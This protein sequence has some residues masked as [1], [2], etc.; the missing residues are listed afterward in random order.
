LFLAVGAFVISWLEVFSLLPATLQKWIEAAEL[1]QKEYALASIIGGALQAFVSALAVMSPAQRNADKYEEMLSLLNK[2]AD[3]ELARVR[4]VVA[5]GS[6][7]AIISVDEFTTRVSRDLAEEARE[8]LLLHQ[9]LSDQTLGRSTG[10]QF[11]PAT[12]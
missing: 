7:A 11:S 9:A 4:E 1:G 3:S 10:Q 5:K 8:W 12:P 6:D 2:Y